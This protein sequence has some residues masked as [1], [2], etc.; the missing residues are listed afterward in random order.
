MAIS[1]PKSALFNH[2]GEILNNT[3]PAFLF[4]LV[5]S[6]F[7]WLFGWF[8]FLPLLGANPWRCNIPS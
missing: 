7:V 5:L 6:C 4:C 2:S 3:S 8:F 1:L